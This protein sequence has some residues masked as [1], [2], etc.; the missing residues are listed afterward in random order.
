MNYFISKI[1]K[2]IPVIGLVL[3]VWISTGHVA[4][5]GL[6]DLGAF[7]LVVAIMSN[8]LQMLL[9][10]TAWFVGLTGTL[11][12]VSM[13]LT[14]HLGAFI[15]DT[16]VIY[17]VW[18]IVRD[19]SSMVL[20]FF[21]L[22]AA[23]KMILEAEEANY[24]QLLK[25]IVIMGILINFSFFFTRVLIDASNV[26]SLQ[27]YNAI[28]PGKEYAAGS[29]V[30]DWS[31]SLFKDGGISNIFMNSLAI[32]EWY[33]SRGQLGVGAGNNA[34]ADAQSAPIRIILITIGGMIV[35]IIASL[36]FA[37]AAAAAL[38]RT[39]ILIFLLAFSPIWIASWAL[40]QIREA[41]KKWTSH[42]RAQLLFLPVYLLF[43]YVAIRILTE[44]HLKDLAGGDFSG[45][46]Q[47]NLGAYVS[48]FVGFSIV[49]VMLNI[50]LV[51]AVSVAG[52]GGKLSEKWFNQTR[53][54]FGRHTVGRA[55]YNVQESS[56]FKDFEANHP[57]VGSMIS[58]GLSKGSTYGFGLKK[59]GYEDA[60]KA[61]KKRYEEAYK[62]VG[63][64]NE[65]FIAKEDLPSAKAA[66]KEAQARFRSNLPYNNSVIGFM[67][68]NRAYKETAHKLNKDSDKQAK[69]D[70]KKTAQKKMRDLIEEE[71]GLNEPSMI[72]LTGRL[73]EETARKKSE[74]LEQ[75]RKEKIALQEQIAEG[76]AVEEE[77]KESKIMNKLEE[78]EKKSDG[79]GDKGGDKGGEKSEK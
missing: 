73:A 57:G 51:A 74:R 65:A 1:K 43:M 2:Y 30:S 14:T 45:L 64:V 37:G 72:Q 35:M 3:F 8:L 4:H 42:F 31:L 33:K 66:A 53:S 49:I 11:L 15:N 41:S 23:I 46:T 77:E 60:L 9:T 20:I 54:W 24:A 25:S 26:V 76:T 10:A 5:A 61:K 78:I 59:G 38:L 12:N 40:P 18:G 21:I 70:N 63:T 52:A 13:Y 28:A 79:G 36:S 68:D 67:M 34:V 71:R 48:L 6:L 56:R 44:S 16:P 27:F 22:Y 19:L 17:T 75:I 69:K 7:D 39:V 58:K 32:N 50:P 29:S 55:A 62:K 47:G